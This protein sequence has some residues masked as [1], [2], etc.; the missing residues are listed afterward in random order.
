MSRRLMARVDRARGRGLV[1]S[2]P[3]TVAQRHKERLRQ[4]RMIRAS[5]IFDQEWYETQADTT[6]DSVDSAIDDYL[7]HGARLGHSPHPLFI[8]L[9][10]AWTGRS[11]TSDAPLMSYLRNSGDRWNSATSPL[12]DPAMLDD[13]LPEDEFG[14]LSSFLRNRG[15]DAPLPYN[16]DAAFV[17]E[18][19]TLDDVRSALLARCKE[20]RARERQAAL[21]RMSRVEPEDSPE[22]AQ[23]VRRFEQAGATPPLVSIILPTWNRAEKLRHAIDSVTAQSYAQWELIVVDDGS[24]DDTASVLESAAAKDRRVVPI[25]MPHRGVSAARNVA[26]SRS[27]GKY[28]AFLDSDNAWEPH[29]L[30]SMVAFLEVNGHDAGYC[31][32]EVELNGTYFYRAGAATTQSLRIGNSIPQPALVVSRAMIELAGGYDESLPRAVDYDLILSLTDHTEFALVPF[33]GVRYSEGDQDPNRISEAQSIAWNFYVRDRHLWD[34]AELAPVE[35]DLVTVVIDGVKSADEAEIVLTN[36]REHAGGLPIE[37][38]LIAGTNSWATLRDITL[39]EFSTLDVRVVA[40]A[41]ASVLPLRINHALRMAR[42]EFVYVTTSLHRFQEGT[43]GQLLASL[44]DLDAAVTHPVVLDRKR[45]VSDA[46]VVYAPGGRDPIGLLSGLPS[47][48]ATWTSR[49]IE[50]PGAT[51]PLLLRAST[52]RGIKGVS[53]KLKQLWADIDTAQSA[54]SYEAKPIVVRTD[55]VVRLSQASP[56]APGEGSEQDARM[57]ASLW[58]QAPV[59]S[60]GAISAAGAAASYTGFTSVS[61]P[62]DPDRWSRA[63]WRPAP[64]DS[65]LVVTD[66]PDGPLQWTIVMG[67][68][69]DDRALSWGD[70]HFAHSMASALRS[71]GQ[72]VAV[73]FAAN[74]RAADGRSDDVVLTLRGLKHPPIPAGATSIIW[75]IS[76][77]DDITAQELAAYDLRYAASST[78]PVVMKEQWGV[79]IT[80]L[81]Q[82]TDPDRFYLDDTVVD[83]VRGKALM[84][85][86]TRNH[87]RMAACEAA[88]AGYPVAVYG[89]GWDGFVDEQV[90]LGTYV[91]NEELRRYYRSAEWVLN[92]HWSDMRDH[93]FISNRVFDVLASGGRLITDDVG[94]LD[95]LLPE[96]L[97]P[98]GLATFASP[99]SLAS[100]LESGAQ[101]FYADEVLPLVSDHIRSAHSFAARAQVLLDDVRRHRAISRDVARAA[102]QP[103]GTPP[104]N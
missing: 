25:Q 98:R 24:I 89:A 103:V 73:D 11:K 30:V 94:G 8:P 95:G 77:P 71:L 79:D 68:P 62:K 81:L 78:W 49:D 23:A 48:W 104:V 56:F 45:L 4:I 14:P 28:V 66:R 55:T 97:L 87:Y 18:G 58:P 76:H 59:G 34:R 27:Q 26:L 52:V 91:P 41:D 17:R 46:G 10:S 82:C 61:L 2:P 42:G 21:V 96:G 6:F 15:A 64:L 101:A 92:D 53:T 33:V 102:P 35:P 47:D 83:E 19:L 29:F 63:L 65:S 39:A 86:N 38:I 20:Q 50:V 75:V 43:I 5:L 93:G 36:I 37:V 7:E 3:L 54:A 80:P 99:I 69:A 12:F 13:R 60:Q 1:A 88:R 70:Y 16:R 51:L 84:V 72:R 100:T 90:I 67:A 31:M 44:I 57:F 22:V 74:L 85:G 32:S 9:G 40:V